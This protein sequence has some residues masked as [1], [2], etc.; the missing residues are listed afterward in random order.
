[1]HLGQH[2]MVMILILLTPLSPPSLVRIA[3]HLSCLCMRICA[4]LLYRASTYTTKGAL[5]SVLPHVHELVHAR[6]SS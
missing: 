6:T 2:T 1:M 4:H 5:L 3:P